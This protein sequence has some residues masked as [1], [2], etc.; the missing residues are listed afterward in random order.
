MEN[1]DVAPMVLKVF[2]HKPAVTMVR[3]V[4]AAQ[5][6]AVYECLFGNRLLNT[7]LLHQIE[8]LSL[9]RLP[10]FVLLPVL[11]QHLLRRR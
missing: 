2:C 1:V 4:L 11:V 3:F 9:V 5:K 6:A 10:I 8:E 7:P